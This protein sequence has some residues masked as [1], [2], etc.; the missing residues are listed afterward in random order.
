MWYR[1][2]V[3]L[4]NPQL[5]TLLFYI[6]TSCL[7]DFFL[8]FIDKFVDIDRL[9]FIDLKIDNIDVKVLFIKF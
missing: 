7:D 1:K 2:G 3:I 4:E 9:N 5:Q 8:S 6:T